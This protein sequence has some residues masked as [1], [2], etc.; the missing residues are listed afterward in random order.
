MNTGESLSMKTLLTDLFRFLRTT[1]SLK[2]VS[3]AMKE[4]LRGVTRVVYMIYLDYPD[5]LSENCSDFCNSL[6]ENLLQIRN[7]L[8]SAHPAS[9]NLPRPSGSEGFNM[10]RLMGR[11]DLPNVPP[12]YDEIAKVY[13]IKETV[14]FWFMT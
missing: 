7:I 13:G 11:F 10:E 12:K 6:G 2:V 5:F 1:F 8:V 3:D 9:I 14:D 4:F